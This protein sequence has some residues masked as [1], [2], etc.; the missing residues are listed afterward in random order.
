MCDISARLQ[1]LIRSIQGRSLHELYPNH[2][3]QNWPYD[4]VQPYQCIGIGCGRPMSYE[5]LWPANKATPRAMCPECYSEW[6]SAL[7]EQCPVCGDYL[8]KWRVD[9]QKCSP[10]EV[11]FRV[12]DGRCLD[13]F[14][15]LSGKALGQDM[16][17]LRDEYYVRPRQLPR[18]TI[19]HEHQ[20]YIDAQY[21]D[22]RH[23]PRQVLR[24]PAPRQRALPPPQEQLRVR[25]QF[26]EP[27][28]VPVRRT[29][30]GKGVKY[31][32]RD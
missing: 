1:A 19:R 25:G 7:T 17:F 4:R 12:H 30:K 8:E 22:L 13:Y 21:V 11:S 32:H 24:V 20:D 16:S 23:Q 2:F 14:S 15:L 6:T 29:Y 27:D 5:E 26:E 9:N 18:Q 31:I 28:S 10:N 3:M